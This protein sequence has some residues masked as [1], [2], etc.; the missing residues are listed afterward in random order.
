LDGVFDGVFESERVTDGVD[1]RDE[2]GVLLALCVLH[3][4]LDAP[5]CSIGL[6]NADGLMVL[7]PAR[8]S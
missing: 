6:L 3:L 4:V 2:D 7:T 5:T 1:V 8:H